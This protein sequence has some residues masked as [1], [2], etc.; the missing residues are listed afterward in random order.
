MKKVFKKIRKISRKKRSG[1]AI[2]MSLVTMTLLVLLGLAVITLSMGNLQVNQA[3][4]LNNDAYYAAEAG[5]NSAIEQIKYETSNYYN[6]MLEA[7]GAYYIAL[8][9][10]FFNNISGNADT[11]FAEPIVSDVST[12]TSFSV[13]DI[14]PIENTGEFLITCTSTAP[15]GAQYKVSGRLSVK[16]VDVRTTEQ[17]IW[18]SPDAALKAGGFLDLGSRNS[19][20][21][22]GG[23][24]LVGNLLYT[25][26]NTNPYTIND[27]ELIIDPNVAL[28][29]ED[30]LEYMSYTDPIITNPDYYI[31]VSQTINWSTIPPPPISMATAEGIDIHFANCTVPEGIVYVKGDVS[32]NNAVVYSDI[33][34]DGNVDISNY[35]NITGNIYCRGNVYV[36]NSDLTGSIY[37]DGFVDFGNGTT[38]ASIYAEDGISIHTA[39]TSG[40]LFSPAEI[41]IENATIADGIIYSKTKLTIGSG[42][43]DG[44]FFSGGDI[45]FTGDVSIDGSVIGKQ[46]IYFKVDANKD[47]YVN[48]NY[49]IETIDAIVNDPDNAF[50]FTAPGEPMLDEYVIFGQ[51]VDA[52]GRLN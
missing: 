22:T 48:Y 7:Q 40:N 24:V 25:E 49:S 3:D 32:L 23:N 52:D 19:V 33:Y 30:K 15:D 29:I 36:T 9:N 35:C 27:G 39:T 14:D 10:G 41:V 28:S 1:A 6:Q 20:N 4:A 2:I 11:D 43:M 12:Y 51:D 44:I 17:Y 8:Y 47:L 42:D 46:D 26:L 16:R 31:T 37:C 45:E 50:F 38:S 34:C 13:G 18:I 21:V 5:V